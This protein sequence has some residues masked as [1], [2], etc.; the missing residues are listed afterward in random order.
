MSYSYKTRGTCSKQIDVELDG[1]KV[2]SVKFYGGCNGNTNGIS[3][4]VKG[5]TVEEVEEKL[6][7]I[8]CGFKSTSCPDQ[9][10]KAVRLAYEEA[11][12]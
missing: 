5:M 8:T 1:N 12:K 11:N 3:T 2:K 7:G 6:T 9:L 10:A 4:L